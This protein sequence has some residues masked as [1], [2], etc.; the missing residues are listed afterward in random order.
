MLFLFI[1]YTYYRLEETVLLFKRILLFNET[2]LVTNF[3]CYILQNLNIL[4]PTASNRLGL[5]NLPSK[6]EY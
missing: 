6:N 5:L 1:S 2:S 4:K 3:A